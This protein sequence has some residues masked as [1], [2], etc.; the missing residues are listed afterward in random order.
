MSENDHFNLLDEPWIV[1]LLKDGTEAEMSILGVLETAQD[2]L[3]IGG[4]LPTQSFAILRLLLAF[5][6]RAI[7]GPQDTAHWGELWSADQL[8]IQQLRTYASVHHDRFDLFGAEAPFFQVADLRTATNE[9]SSLARIVADIPNNEPMF[10]MR[11]RASLLGMP[12]PETARWLVHVHA[13]DPSGI[14]SGAVG[15]P[16]VKGGRGYPIGP[17]WT[18]QI[19]AVVPTGRDLRETLVLNLVPREFGSYVRI[20][21]PGDLPPWERPPNTAVW[22]EREPAGAIEL[23]TWQTRRV[24][25]LHDGLMCTGLVLANGDKI[26]PQNRHQLDPHSVWRHSEPQS[27]KLKTLV[28][29]PRLHRQE[30]AM[31]RGLEAVLPSTSGRGSRGSEPKRFLA[32]GVLQSIGELVGQD[33]LDEAYGVRTRA[34]GM[35]YGAQNATTTDIFDDVL[36]MSVALLRESSPELGT[37]AVDAVST[38]EA[39]VSQLL[40]LAANLAAAAGAS[41]SGASDRA[42]ELASAAV[43]QPYR[44]WLVRVQPGSNRNELRTAWQLAVRSVIEDQA[45]DLLR[46]AGPGAWSGRDVRGHPMNVAR[47]ELQFRS[48]IRKA[49]P[50]AFMETTET[51]LEI[52]SDGQEVMA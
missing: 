20:G 1:V 29:M 2:I 3:E 38:A 15:D 28:Y 17:G 45:T 47:A 35:E 27:A 6:H 26:Q 5:T 37:L 10:T 19:G 44:S 39:A 32:P 51:S 46:A 22:T 14:K 52:Q 7:D 11:S 16:T 8:P 31:W 12:A 34:I 23:Y 4:E 36:P 50:L 18:G 13:Y 33:M 49:L 30:S 42:R 21:G 24:R 40:R 9:A 43:D 48:G 25:L 41:D